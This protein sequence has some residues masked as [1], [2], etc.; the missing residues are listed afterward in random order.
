MKLLA[1][2]SEHCDNCLNYSMFPCYELQF[3]PPRYRSQ[4]PFLTEDQ[5]CVEK[6]PSYLVRDFV[7]RRVFLFNPFM[8][9]IAI[10]RNPVSRLL[11]DYAQVRRCRKLIGF[12]TECIF[13]F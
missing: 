11:S 6:T 4:M 7:P 8:K 10:L 2:I 1:I 3:Y 9:L 5:I 13:D 12:C